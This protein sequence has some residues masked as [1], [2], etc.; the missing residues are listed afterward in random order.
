MIQAIFTKDAKGWSEMTITG[1]AGSGEYGFDIICASV[2]VLA[3]NFINSV[4]LMTKQMPV[5]DSVDDGGHLVVRRPDD[6]TEEGYRIWQT[7][8]E[9]VVIGLTNLSENEGNYVKKPIIH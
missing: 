4:E 3:F 5:V 9:S 7:L 8:F 6:L 2:S 1:H